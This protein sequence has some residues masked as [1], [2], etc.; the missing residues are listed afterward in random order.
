MGSN[1]RSTLKDLIAKLLGEDVVRRIPL[2]DLSNR[3]T[4]GFLKRCRVNYCSEV[5]VTSVVLDHVKRSGERMPVE[6][7]FGGMQN[8][9]LFLKYFFDTN[10]MPRIADNSFGA[11]RRLAKL[12]LPYRFVDSPR[13]G[14]IERKKDPCILDKISTEEELSGILNLI[15]ERAPVVIK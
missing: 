12:D 13:E 11:D 15:L 1:G 2:K 3:F 8:V 10:I 5:E 6:V 4:N 7:K 14:T 9:S